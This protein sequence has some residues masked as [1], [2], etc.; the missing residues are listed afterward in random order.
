M[1]T[2]AIHY[3]ELVDENPD[4]S[5]TMCVIAEDILDKFGD[6]VQNGWVL[7]VGD[8]KTYTHLMN[9]KKQYSSAFQKLSLQKKL[10]LHLQCRWC[11][12]VVNIRCVTI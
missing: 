7:L 3:L 10:Y 2:S 8:G 12:S 5:E 1:K 11:K 6:K 4:S 9:I